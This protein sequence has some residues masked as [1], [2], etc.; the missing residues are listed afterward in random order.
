MLELMEF[1]FARDSAAFAL[2]SSFSSFSL[3][4]GFKGNVAG[5]SSESSRTVNQYL[6]YCVELDHLAVDAKRIPVAR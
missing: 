2:S 4:S 5:S 1:F 3:S 6:A